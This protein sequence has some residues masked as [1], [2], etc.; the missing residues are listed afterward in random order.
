[1]LT[2]AKGLVVPLCPFT[3]TDSVLK[4][5]LPA[6]EGSAAP[7]VSAPAAIAPSAPAISPRFCAP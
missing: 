5:L 2:P 4:S 6:A 3:F 7:P 1:M